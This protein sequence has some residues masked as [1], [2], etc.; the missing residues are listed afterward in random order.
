VS[1]LA[2]VGM[3]AFPPAPIPSSDT[4]VL[5]DDDQGVYFN[6]VHDPADSESS[7]AGL[8]S[9]RPSAVYS[10]SKFFKMQRQRKHEEMGEFRRFVQEVKDHKMD[11]L[12]LLVFSPFWILSTYFYFSTASEQ[13]EWLTNDSTTADQ[14]NEIFGILVPCV[15]FVGSMAAGRMCDLF[16]LHITTLTMLVLQ[17]VFVIVSVIQNVSVQYATFVFIITFRCMFWVVIP[18]FISLQFEARSFGRI[19]GFT[20]SVGGI[21][22]LLAWLIDDL[23]QYHMDGSYFVPNIAFGIICTAT[24]LVFLWY[25]RRSQKIEDI[26]ASNIVSESSHDLRKWRELISE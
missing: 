16:G 3:F 14:M 1:I 15:G 4:L 22:A 5:M 13:L 7:S 25:A 8:I 23:V 9:H 26:R 12:V 2:V 21:V 11:M 6:T 19:Y 17:V 18:R 24:G 20:C 10:K